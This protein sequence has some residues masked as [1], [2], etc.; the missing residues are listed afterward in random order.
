MKGKHRHL[1]WAGPTSQFFSLT[2]R[3]LTNDTDATL[4]LYSSCVGD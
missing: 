2:D 3:D 4:L 1:Q